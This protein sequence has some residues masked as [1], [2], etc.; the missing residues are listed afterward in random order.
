MPRITLV[1][2]AYLTPDEQDVKVT[3]VDDEGVR[4]E[5]VFSREILDSFLKRIAALLREAKP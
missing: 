4:R 1:P 5:F 2:R 3:M